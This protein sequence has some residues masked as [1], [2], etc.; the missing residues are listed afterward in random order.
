MTVEPMQRRGVAGRRWQQ[1][2]G[3]G[4]AM[5]IVRES[6]HAAARR[7]RGGQDVGELLLV[8]HGDALLRPAVDPP[9]RSINGLEAVMQESCDRIVY[10]PA[11]RVESVDSGKLAHHDSLQPLTWVLL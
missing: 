3:R 11:D 2:A 4:F 7:R 9:R 10:L 8:G 5:H 6:C 1:H